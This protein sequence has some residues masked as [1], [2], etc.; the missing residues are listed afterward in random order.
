MHSSR[1]RHLG[2]EAGSVQIWEGGAMRGRERERGR[3][4]YS[5]V[6]LYFVEEMGLV[7]L[8]GLGGRG[9]GVRFA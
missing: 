8:V 7:L 2:G 1:G 3:S 6:C 5:C 9:Y 4:L